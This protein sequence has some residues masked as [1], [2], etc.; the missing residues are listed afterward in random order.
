MAAR[1]LD[2]AAADAAI[3]ASREY[4]TYLTDLAEALRRHTTQL[5]ASW[6]GQSYHGFYQALE[7]IRRQ[8]DQAH[9]SCTA[10]VSRLDAGLDRARAA[11]READRKADELKRLQGA[12]RP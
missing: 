10:A 4:A 3:R 8:I 5:G 7:E 6:Q 2:H 1:F 11:E 9:V 12:T